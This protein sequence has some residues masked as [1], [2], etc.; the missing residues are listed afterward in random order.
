MA[1]PDWATVARNPRPDRPQPTHDMDLTDGQKLTLGDTTVTLVQLPGHTPGTVGMIVPARF[2]GQMHGVFIMSGTQM[3][4]A[5]SLAAFAHAFDDLAKPARVEAMLGSHPD[6]LMNTLVA[7]EGV[8]DH[9]PTGSHPFLRGAERTARYMDIM[10]ECGRA[11]L[12][13]LAVPRTTP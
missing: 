5:A 13:A 10:I 1:A 12:A 6:I 2:G 3:P 4:T 9:Y 7:M 11:R 8:R